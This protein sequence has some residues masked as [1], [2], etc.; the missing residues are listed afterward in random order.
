M[1]V[2]KAHPR[3]PW[4]IGYRGGIFIPSDDGPIAWIKRA[5]NKEDYRAFGMPVEIWAHR[6]SPGYN[7]DPLHESQSFTWPEGVQMVEGWL[8]EIGLWG[9]PDAVMWQGL[10]HEST[11][12]S[13]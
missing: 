8:D 9:T 13:R 10:R 11:S 12:Q 2:A 3:W 4:R 1:E 5:R 6:K 7:G